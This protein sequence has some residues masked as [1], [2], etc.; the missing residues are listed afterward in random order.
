MEPDCLV[1]V[2]RRVGGRLCWWG[3]VVHRKWLEVGK[4]Q[5]GHPGDPRA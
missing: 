1:G 2:I 5:S 3:Q 4:S